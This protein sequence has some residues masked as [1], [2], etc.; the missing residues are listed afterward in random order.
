MNAHDNNSIFRALQA[1]QPEFTAKLSFAEQDALHAADPDK[2][3]RYVDW[4]FGVNET[5][6]RRRVRQ[7]ATAHRDTDAEYERDRT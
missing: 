2:Y 5:V 7:E 3:W 4:L 6:V 1:M